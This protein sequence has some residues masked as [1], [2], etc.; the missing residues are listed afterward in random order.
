MDPIDFEHSNVNFVKPE[1]WTDEQCQSLPV[2]KGVTED[3][4]PLHISCW[5]PTELEIADIVAGKPIYL[6]VLF[7]VQ[8]PV[9]LSTTDPF[10]EKA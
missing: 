6:H 5:K 10:T 1:G 8:M 7:N 9:M 3:G 4:F 2:F